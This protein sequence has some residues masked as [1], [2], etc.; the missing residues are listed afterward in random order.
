MFWIWCITVV[1]FTWLDVGVCVFDLMQP[2]ICDWIEISHF[3]CYHC[4]SMYVSLW[5]CSNWISHWIGLLRQQ[6]IAF[7]LGV[8]YFLTRKLEPCSTILEEPVPVS[9]TEPGRHQ[10]FNKWGWGIVSSTSWSKIRALWQ[11]IIRPKCE[12]YTYF[13]LFN[14]LDCVWISW[15]CYLMVY[16]EESWPSKLGL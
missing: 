13:R 8:L 12:V 11:L 16:E 14:I 5:I 10:E 3:V 6:I 7:V 4:C 15:S 2:S 9:N 1:L